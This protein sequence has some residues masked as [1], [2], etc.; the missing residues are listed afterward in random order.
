MD[1]NIYQIKTYM[2]AQEIEG[3]VRNKIPEEYRNKV[4]KMVKVHHNEADNSAEFTFVLFGDNQEC[5]E[6]DRRY[7]VAL[8]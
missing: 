6:D 7:K 2:T 3:G 8:D 4:I 5:I 1:N